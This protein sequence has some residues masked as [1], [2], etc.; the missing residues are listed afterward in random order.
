[1]VRGECSYV[2]CCQVRLA[3]TLRTLT[4]LTPYF[5]A[6]DDADLLDDRMAR[7]SSSVS[8]ADG[9]RSPTN[10]GGGG[11]RPRSEA[12][13]QLSS[14]VP[15]RKCAG[16]QQGGL[17]QECNTNPCGHLSVFNH[18]A[19]RCAVIAV[20]AP[21]RLL[22]S[23]KRPYP[24]GAQCPSQGQHPFLPADRSICFQNLLRSPSVGGDPMAAC[25]R[26]CSRAARV[27]LGKGFAPA[28][29]LRPPQ[30]VFTD[31]TGV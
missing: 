14:A 19:T 2:T 16:L 7:T 28:P 8:L 23:M 30:P 17:S 22:R 26:S 5:C 27:S 12:S 13:C 29:A 10:T 1:M 18:N 20:K 15:S 24:L 6:N 4:A 31:M 21:V 11:A 9:L 3:R 25:L